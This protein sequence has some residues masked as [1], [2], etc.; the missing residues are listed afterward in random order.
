MESQTRPDYGDVASQM[1]SIFHEIRALYDAGT[2][3]FTKDNI[4]KVGKELERFQK[5]E[6]D[7]GGKI[8]I[9]GVNG[10]DYEIFVNPPPSFL[11]PRVNQ[12]FGGSKWMIRY[13]SV[14]TLTTSTYT[15]SELDIFDPQSA[16]LPMRI[17]APIRLLTNFDPAVYNKP[18]APPIEDFSTYQAIEQQWKTSQHYAQLQEILSTIEIPFTLTKVIALAL[19]SLVVNSQISKRCFLQHAFV[20]TLHSTLVRRGILSVSSEKYVQDPGYTQRDKDIIHSAG[21]TVLNDPQALLELDESSVLVS[22]NADIPTGDI[23][24]DI[25][26]PGILIWEEGRI[27]PRGSRVKRMIE[28]EYSE[29]SLPHH[30]CFGVS[31]MVMLIRKST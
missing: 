13:F 16:Y 20:S 1:K 26:R 24:A 31:R 17:F 25:C 15:P 12:V 30:E 7:N 28:N 22:I 3:F 23:V 29:I 10:V 9:K 19:G 18:P 14:E 8:T 4:Q 27:Q 6:Q 2:P 11:P 21:L 5:G